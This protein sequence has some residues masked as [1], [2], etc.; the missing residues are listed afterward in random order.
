MFSFPVATVLS[1]AL[2]LFAITPPAPVALGPIGKDTPAREPQMAARGSSVFLTFGAGSSIYFSSS[3][4]AGKSFSQ[5]VRV[6]EAA[7]LP[8]SR[9][10]G[11][12]IAVSGRAIV[13]TAVTGKTLS[14]GPHAHGLPSDGDLL[15]WRSLDEGKT[16]SKGVRVND[17][18]GAP[19]E[20]LHALASDSR[21]NLFAAWLD[22][23]S[24][25]GTQLFGALSSDS[26]V[27][28]QKNVLIYASPD[29]SICE[30]CHP[31]AAFDADGRPVVMW[32]NELE[33]ARDLYLS[34]AN[35][36]GEFEAPAKLGQGSWQLNACPM[37]GGGMAMAKGKLVTAWRRNKQIYLASPGEKEREVA[38]GSDVSLAGTPRGI[39]A[40]WSSSEGVK[41]LVP[42]SKDPTTLATQGT[43][44]NIVAL[45]N[46]EAVAAWE[47]EGRIFLQPVR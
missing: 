43:F 20:G 22:K 14:E 17:I 15:A 39:Y 3:Q 11:P 32:R 41:A 16:W 25:K 6:A 9:H 13:I 4:D 24:G 34:R 23:R 38:T 19:T 8:L 44:P 46:G 40:V 31:S 28:W 12:R 36:A 42:G 18:P 21:G 5:P 35:S 26:G 1:S 2:C 37:D 27:T 10:R 33:G 45:A 7:I 29:G 30:C 47:L